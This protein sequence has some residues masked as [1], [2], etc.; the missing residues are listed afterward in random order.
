MIDVSLID[1]IIKRKLYLCGWN[2]TINYNITNI[3]ETLN[4]EGYRIFPYAEEI[5]HFFLN[6]EILFDLKELKK[7]HAKR[8]KCY[9]DVRFNLLDTAS[10]MYDYYGSLSSILNE[11][12]YP[13]GS[14]NDCIC[15]LVG[16]SKR[17]YADVKPF[18]EIL[19]TD[20][21]DFLNKII[22]YKKFW[23]F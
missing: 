16:E 13:I 11:H 18:P 6:T 10:G 23:I 22:A 20:I 3:V 19:G 7:L 8:N 4:K 15:I 2:E 14:I 17:I 5:L 12:V 1:P 9:G 21:V